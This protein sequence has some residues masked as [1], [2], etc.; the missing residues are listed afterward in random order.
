MP[1]GHSKET[2]HA[3]FP[4]ARFAHG[5]ASLGKALCFRCAIASGDAET[6]FRASAVRSPPGHQTLAMGSFR[7]CSCLITAAMALVSKDLVA[8]CAR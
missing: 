3:Y 2:G 5:F 8:V 1:A 7:L 6:P 4:A